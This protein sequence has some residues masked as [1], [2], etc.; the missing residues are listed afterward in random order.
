MYSPFETIWVGTGELSPSSTASAGVSFSNCSSLNQ[1]S[2]SRESGAHFDMS[3]SGG[4]RSACRGLRGIAVR[5]R[6]TQS[7]CATGQPGV[8][9]PPIRAS[10]AR[11][12]MTLR[13]RLPRSAAA[14][15][16]ADI[17]RESG[18][19][20]AAL[21]PS[22]ARLDCRDPDFRLFL[23]FSEHPD[24]AD[25]SLSAHPGLPEPRANS[26]RQRCGRAVLVPT[27]RR[28]RHPLQPRS[29]P[30]PANV[31][32][33]SSGLDVHLFHLREVVVPGELLVRAAVRGCVVVDVAGDPVRGELQDPLGLCNV[34]DAARGLLISLKSGGS[35]RSSGPMVVQ[36][37]SLKP[38]R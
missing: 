38:L 30:A 33:P 2:A 5:R 12:K 13:Q 17:K 7:Q 6:E 23:F 19:S 9:R 37:Y 10:I 3:S 28:V 15:Q 31:I 16:I 4:W 27:A 14:T 20:V 8:R 26:S 22:D 21:R 24:G 11:E 18:R 25:G 32:R 36:T 29:Q 35:S 34:Y 1:E